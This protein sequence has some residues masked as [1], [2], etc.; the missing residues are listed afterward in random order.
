MIDLHLT[1]ALFCLEKMMMKGRGR[2]PTR[3]ARL[4]STSI[5]I[6]RVANYTR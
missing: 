3:A 4:R 1:E 2:F 5:P 6:H